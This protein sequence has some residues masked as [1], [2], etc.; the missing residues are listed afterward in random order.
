MTYGIVIGILILALLAT[1]IAVV[2]EKPVG[3]EPVDDDLELEPVVQSQVITAP[4]PVLVH[5]AKEPELAPA[6]TPDPITVVVDQQDE[7]ALGTEPETAES[8]ESS[9]ELEFDDPDQ[10]RF[11]PETGEPINGDAF[12]EESSPPVEAAYRPLGI[13]EELFAI[14]PEPDVHRSVVPAPDDTTDAPP[15]Q[16]PNTTDNVEHVEE[17]APD[18]NGSPESTEGSDSD[19]GS[20]RI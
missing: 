4:A 20:V 16:S 6:E 13:T 10:W 15:D 3:P 2:V 1:L 19:S 7:Q 11:D 18:E 14:H 9:A 5:V 12:H 17:P 8:P